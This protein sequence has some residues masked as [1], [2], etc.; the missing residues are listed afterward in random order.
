MHNYCM[1]GFVLRRSEPTVLVPAVPAVN[2]VTS[3]SVPI[4]LLLPPRR[5][6]R[7]FRTRDNGVSLGVAKRDLFLDRPR[8]VGLNGSFSLAPSTGAS[9]REFL[10]CAS[11]DVD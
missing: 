5:S 6:G 3:S 4:V 1:S 11:P 2:A 8:G 10:S 7:S 9:L